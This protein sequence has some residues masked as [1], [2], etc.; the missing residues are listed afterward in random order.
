LPS[1]PLRSAWL[2]S[3]A[4][5]QSAAST[6]D[7]DQPANFPTRP[8]FPA[9]TTT[10]PLAPT[11]TIA[12]KQTMRIGAILLAGGRSGRMGTAKEWLPYHG[13]PLLRAV[14][15]ALQPACAPI[16]VVARDPEQALPTLPDGVLRCHDA[17]PGTG[18][19]AGVAAGLATLAGTRDAPDLVLLAGCDMPWLRAAHVAALAAHCGDAAV[20]MVATP[21]G[22][23]PLASLLRLDALP[24]V[25]RLLAAGERSLRSLAGLPRARILDAGLAA[26][27]APDGGLWRNANTPAEFAE[28]A[29]GVDVD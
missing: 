16:V 10:S 23:Q 28:F 7:P 11:P 14:V 9:H 19:L 13:Q 8:H 26:Q 29:R 18:P 3:R 2:V 21:A 20:L 6:E 25:E 24:D 4:S 22:I 15:E 1:D 5:T 17:V 12:D 27:L